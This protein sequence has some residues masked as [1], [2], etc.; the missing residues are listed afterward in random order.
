MC[1]LSQS[2]LHSMDRIWNKQRCFNMQ[3][4]NLKE[5][6]KEQLIIC[7]HRGV[8]GGNIPCNTITSYDIAINQGADM[9]ELDVTA[10]A[11]GELF[12]FHPCMETRQLNLHDVDIRK[13]PADEVKKL[14]YANL[15]GFQTSETI[16]L[17]DDVL[18]HL[19]GKCFINVDKFGDNP[20]LIIQKI[21]KH[22]IADQIVL[23]SN[24][25]KEVLDMMETYAPDLQY[26]A[27]ISGKPETHE[28]LMKRN[29][30]YVG[31]EL[32]F[33][34]DFSPLVSDEFL[35]RVHEDGKL[36]WGNGI[37][38]D[39]KRPLAGVH[40]DDTALKGDPDLGWGYFV[41]KGFDI[42]Q[43][44]WPLALSH[45]LEQTNKRKR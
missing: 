6:A 32:V 1:S 3:N 4:F 18:E 45:Y 16:L 36:L 19:K 37:L 2:G 33:K 8:W 44:D 17:L 9:I 14:H 25:Q 40:S 11:D 29:L 35:H 28:M 41:R 39:Y 30:N 21:K 42:I 24:A 23:K 27:I 34:D 7:A 22:N 12:V 31:L 5:R 15:D 20:A 13:L 43:T 10:S 38:F 26:L